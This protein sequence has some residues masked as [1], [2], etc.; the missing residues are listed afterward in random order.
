MKAVP[1]TVEDS[2]LFGDSGGDVSLAHAKWQLSGPARCSNASAEAV[3]VGFVVYL[4]T[5]GQPQ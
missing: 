5:F 2:G 3:C 4:V 1:C